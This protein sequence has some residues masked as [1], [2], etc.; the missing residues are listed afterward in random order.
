MSAD[1]RLSPHADA[2]S[3]TV[4]GSRD[5]DSEPVAVR[6]TALQSGKRDLRHVFRIAL[7]KLTF[8]PSGGVQ[9][10]G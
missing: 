2:A 10:A 6:K 4:V 3:G 5:Q 7:P 9:G 1:S 8:E